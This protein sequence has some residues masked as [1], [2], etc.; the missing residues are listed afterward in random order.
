MGEFLREAFDRRYVLIPLLAVAALVIAGFF[1]AE[2]R[3][4]YTRDLSEFVSDRQESLRMIAELT[5]ATM[6]AESAQRGYLLTGNREYVETFHTAEQT[7]RELVDNLI[8]RFAAT[9]A[10]E[11]P[12]LERVRTA[13]IGKF[14]E[15]D[16][17]IRQMEEG[18]SRSAAAAVK[19]DIGL[20]Y[21]HDIR[22]QLRGLRGRELERM[23]SVLVQWKNGLRVN[24]YINAA[25]TL[26]TLALL[27]LVGWLAA[28]DIRRRV[29]TST[30]L[31][32]L[33]DQ[34]TMDLKELSVHMLKIGEFEKAALARELHDELGGLLVAMRMDLA[35]LRRRI[36]LPDADAEARWKRVD[37]AL[38]SGVELKRRIIEDLRPTLLDNMG[39]VTALRW[40]AEQ[41]CAQAR[42][43]LELDFPE[44]EPALG[45]ETAIAVF[46]CVQELLSNV[47]KHAKATQVKLSLHHSKRLAVIVEDDG[48][49]IPE[50]ARQ[51]MGAHGLKQIAFRMQAVGGEVKTERVVPHGTRTTLEVPL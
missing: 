5:Y 50:G 20:Y 34:G 22:E 4:D 17:T 11:V 6:D 47:L 14:G 40:Q 23:Y 39:L 9:D 26:L 37:G 10:E 49:G 48:V 51:R 16:D 36:T 44:D 15:Q 27:G 7:A 41:A 18:K 3:R 33:V 8:Q 1:V 45:S 32:N 19:T 21:M 28:R 24:T 31:Q 46:R 38:T 30:E 29:A 13:L 25:T 12:V 42:L 43:R 2:A 35:Q